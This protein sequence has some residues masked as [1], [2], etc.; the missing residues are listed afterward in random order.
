MMV[1]LVL[2]A[3]MMA[4]WT[5]P[6]ADVRAECQLQAQSNLEQ[7]DALLWLHQIRLVGKI[8]RPSHERS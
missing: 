4:A 2:A 3:M 7:D 5:G 6:A 1:V 8:L